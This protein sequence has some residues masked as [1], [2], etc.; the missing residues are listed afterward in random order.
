[1]MADDGAAASTSGPGDQSTW[2][3]DLFGAKYAILMRFL[4]ARLRNRQDAEDL[5]QEAFLRLLRVPESELIRQPD[6]YLFR[7]AINLLSEYRMR[8]ARGAVIF[9][10]EAA[11]EASDAAAMGDKLSLTPVDTM[12]DSDHLRWT[13]E[14]LPVRCRTA[15]ILH[16]RDGMTYAQIA[17]VLGV[18]PDTV[19]K[20][21][22]KAVAQCRLAFG[23]GEQG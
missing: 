4:L 23:R 1:M 20:Y 14:Q 8:S 6:A 18:S 19:K 2:A 3:A 7:I 13:L 10:S 9:N 5:A 22:A 15:L 16:R 21:I 11:I 12:I 17:D